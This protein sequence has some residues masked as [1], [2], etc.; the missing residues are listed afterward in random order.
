M[1]TE[2]DFSRFDKPLKQWIKVGIWSLIYVLFV[3]WVGNLW[4]LLLLPVIFDAFIT[5]FIPMDLVEED[6]K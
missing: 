3:V 6:K 4:W 2:K 1:D 5:H